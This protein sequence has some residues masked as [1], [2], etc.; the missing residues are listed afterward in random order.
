F[1]VLRF[2]S[3]L[4]SFCGRIGYVLS[5]FIS[6]DIEVGAQLVNYISTADIAFLIGYTRQGG[7][8]YACF[9]RNLFHSHP[10]PFLK[11]FLSN[12]FLC[13]KS[14]HDCAYREPESR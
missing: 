13:S 6:C 5:N 14:A 12:E 4:L 1:S 10:A 2:V 7:A 11:L 3:I 8:V 9:T